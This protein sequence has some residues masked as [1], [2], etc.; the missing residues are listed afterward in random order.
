MAA[1]TTTE[2]NSG[3]A[4][5]IDVAPA[6]EERRMPAAPADDGSGSAC[7][8][9]RAPPS[10]LQDP[11]QQRRLR[12]VRRRTLLDLHLVGGDV[13]HAAHFAQTLT[14]HVNAPAHLELGLGVGRVALADAGASA[15]LA[16]EVSLALLVDR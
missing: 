15:D 2:T 5:F 6:V 4:L 14:G 16:G 8:A 7:G 9:G 12:S 3:R 13:A 10:S 1:A 11:R